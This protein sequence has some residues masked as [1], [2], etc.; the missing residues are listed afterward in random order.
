MILTEDDVLVAMH[1]FDAPMGAV[2]GK[3]A[4]GVGLSETADQVSGFSFCLGKFPRP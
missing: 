2:E 4:R 3:D 1:D